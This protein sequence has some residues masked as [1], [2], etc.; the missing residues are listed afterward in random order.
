MISVTWSAKVLSL[1]NGPN[2]SK[3]LENFSMVTKSSLVST[4]YH[5]NEYNQYQ[6]KKKRD[7]Y[8]PR[9]SFKALTSS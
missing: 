9:I 7:E 5:L 3:A 8:I 1:E 2:H 6:K 4:A